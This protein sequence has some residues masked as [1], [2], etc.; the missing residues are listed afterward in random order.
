MSRKCMICAAL[1]TSTEESPSDS[2]LNSSENENEFDEDRT[3]LDQA[4]E[5]KVY[6]LKYNVLQMCETRRV[7]ICN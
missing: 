7:S 3:C 4:K 2:V 6:V 1:R 5:R